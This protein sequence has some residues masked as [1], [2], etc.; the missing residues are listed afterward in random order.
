VYVPSRENAVR[1]TAEYLRD[2]FLLFGFFR[3]FD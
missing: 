3:L 1:Q 2:A